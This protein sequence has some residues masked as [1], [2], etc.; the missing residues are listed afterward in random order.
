M[1]Q[2]L[3]KFM[4]VIILCSSWL[5]HSDLLAA[6]TDEED[7]YIEEA[8]AEESADIERFNGFSED[9]VWQVVCTELYQIFHDEKEYGLWE[10]Y[11][12]EKNNYELKIEVLPIYIEDV[13]EMNEKRIEDWEESWKN[14]FKAEVVPED[15]KYYK[16]MAAIENYVVTQRWIGE[17][18]SFKYTEEEQ[19]VFDEYA[20][21]GYIPEYYVNNG[22]VVSNEVSAE[23]EIGN[24]NVSK[25]NKEDKS[26]SVLAF[27]LGGGIT[28]TLMIIAG[29]VYLVLYKK[30]KK[31][32][33][34]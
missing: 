15:T 31:E 32:E 27:F 24:E 10:D 7:Q 6:S 9:I 26:G 12:L 2:Y 3:I 18:V 8:I 1:K 20:K 14:C 13:N 11:Y 21:K 23:P 17:P 22:E 29:I 28:L 19:A 30:R 4:V 16:L 25:E 34:E 33:F 5:P